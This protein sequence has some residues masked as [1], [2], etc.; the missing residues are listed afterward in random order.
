MSSRV[1]PVFSSP[2][3]GLPECAIVSRCPAIYMGAGDG[4]Q[5]LT[6]VRRVLPELIRLPRAHR[7]YVLWV[8]FGLFPVQFSL[9]LYS[10]RL[11]ILVQHFLGGTWMALEGGMP[12]WLKVGREYRSCLIIPNLSLSPGETLNESELRE[13]DFPR[14]IVPSIHFC[15]GSVVHGQS[16]LWRE[17]VSSPPPFYF[18]KK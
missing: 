6:F 8:T 2:A 16:Q 5:L 4:A 14:W 15:W 3:P 10:V 11:P 18:V 17:H 1:L 12:C 9:L 13:R 7:L